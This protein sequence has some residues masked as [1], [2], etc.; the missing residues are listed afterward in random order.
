MKTLNVYVPD[1][2]IK[3]MRELFDNLG[4]DW[5]FGRTIDAEINDL[6]E[7]PSP[8]ELDEEARKKAAKV[9]EESLKDVISRI[10]EMRKGRT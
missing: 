7:R 2:K 3:F 10:E 5:S 8:Y 9:R 1:E 6:P 4:L